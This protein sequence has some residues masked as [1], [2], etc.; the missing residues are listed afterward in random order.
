M[1]DDPHM[2][3]AVV[4]QLLLV[5]EGPFVFEDPHTPMLYPVVGASC[6]LRLHGLFGV[7]FLLE[8]VLVCREETTHACSNGKCWYVVTLTFFMDGFGSPWWYSLASVCERCGVHNGP[9]SSCR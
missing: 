4:C 7:V 9:G 3:P 5:R 6:R 1:L 8:R 2:Y